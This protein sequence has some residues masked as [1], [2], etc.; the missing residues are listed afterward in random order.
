MALEFP[1]SA[2]QGTAL[3]NGLPSE[4]PEASRSPGFRAWKLSSRGYQVVPVLEAAWQRAKFR[5]HD[6]YRLLK[7]AG[8]ILQEGVVFAEW[9]E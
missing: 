2:L 1:S 9:S 4:P 7:K 8:V 6:A 5:P 3:P